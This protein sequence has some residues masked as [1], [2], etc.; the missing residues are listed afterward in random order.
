MFC[1]FKM[2]M[3]MCYTFQIC[4]VLPS[5]ERTACKCCQRCT[6]QICVVLP[7]MERTTCKCCR[8][9]TFQICVIVML[10]EKTTCKCCRCCTFQI[11]VVS[12]LMERTTCQCCQRSTFQWGS[13]FIRRALFFKFCFVREE[14]LQYV[15]YETFLLNEGIIRKKPNWAWCE[16]WAD[17]NKEAKIF[18]DQIGPK[19]KVK[20]R[21][22]SLTN[23]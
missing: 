12:T 10:M 1:Y 9:C 8:R 18:N 17:P 11:C 5:M 19:V 15:D 20:F 22:H 21:P 6:F 16:Y 3:S 4:V 14:I 2:S 7:S 13:L 23:L